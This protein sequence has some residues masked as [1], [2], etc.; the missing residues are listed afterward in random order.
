MLNNLNLVDVKA[1]SDFIKGFQNHDGGIFDPLIQKKS[2]LYRYLNAIRCRDFNNIFGVQ[3]RRA[4]TRQSFA[5][6]RCLGQKPNVPY[7]HIPYSKDGISGYV[8]SLNWSVP[9]GAGS[10]FSHLIFFMRMNSELFQVHSD[11]IGDLLECAFKEVSRYRQK[12]GSWHREGASL[13]A[14]QKING[15]MKVM[16]AY[17]VANRDDFDNS[18]GL[19]DLCFSS[20][21]EGDACN[22]FNVIYVLYHCLQKTDYR[23]GEAIDYCLERLKMYQEYWF[24]QYGGFSFL[25]SKANRIYYGASIS[26]GL[27]EPDVHGTH[28]FLWGIVLISDILGWR[29]ELGLRFPIT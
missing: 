14:F 9:W 20:L 13:P 19:I 7:L 10:H 29:E 6:L 17:S 8:H 22:N 2:R 25:P 23:R 28:L 11:E 21:N 12:D 5:A 16:T 1:V 26:K 15:A 4:E 18:E 3:T 27:P 24:P